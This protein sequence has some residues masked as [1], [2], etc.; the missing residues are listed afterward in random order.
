[1]GSASG[2]DCGMA[3]IHYR[4]VQ[5]DGG[6]AYKLG[7]VF[8]ESFGTRSAALAAAHRVAQEQHV[9]GDP[10]TIEYQDEAGRW[11]TEFSAGDDRP[12]ADVEG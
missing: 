3:R 12:E 6:W 5:H 1:M 7:D 8:S 9:P 11:H 4:I 2:K 10:A